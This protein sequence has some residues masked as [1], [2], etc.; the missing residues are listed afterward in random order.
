MVST[1]DADA[2]KTSGTTPTR[3]RRVRNGEFRFFYDNTAIR[4]RRC[5]LDSFCGCGSH[6]S[7]C[8]TESPRRTRER[9]R[10]GGPRKRRA[11]GTGGS[12]RVCLGG[13]SGARR[14]RVE[15]SKL[16]PFDVYGHQAIYIPLCPWSTVYVDPTSCD[17][18]TPRAF[19]LCGFDRWCC[20][21]KGLRARRIR[22]RVHSCIRDT[23]RPFHSS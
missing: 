16:V 11:S 14:R 12:G 3:R 6:S 15:R 2:C 19:A 20:C 18:S 9:N 7:Q 5:P 13:R 17:I 23:K 10:T 21:T 4:S 22:P 1:A 8:L